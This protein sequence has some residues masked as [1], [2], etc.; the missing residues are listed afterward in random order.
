MSMLQF[1]TGRI[2]F[3]YTGIIKNW[4]FEAEEWLKKI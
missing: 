1:K 2:V 4:K 3:N